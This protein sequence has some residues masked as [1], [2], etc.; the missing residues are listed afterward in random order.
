MKEYK[1]YPK[2]IEE[3]KE[4]IDYIIDNDENIDRV[5]NMQNWLNWFDNLNLVL[6]YKLEENEYLRAYCNDNN[7]SLQ[8]WKHNEIVDSAVCNVISNY[9]NEYN[10]ES[11]IVVDDN[12]K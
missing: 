6:Q 12:G 11:T 3:L 7:F 5:K 9:Y 10:N 2:T 1:T 8:I 4:K